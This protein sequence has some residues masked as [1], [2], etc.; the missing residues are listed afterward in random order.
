MS[1]YLRKY[2]NSDSRFLVIDNILVH[3]R[4]QGEGTPVL[5]LHGAFSSLHTYDVWTDYLLDNG[6]RVIRYDLPGF[7][8]TGS[9]L[10]K[11]YS[12]DMYKRSLLAVM[13]GLNLDNCHIV[14]NSLGGWLAWEFALSY[15]ER[16]NRIVLIASAGFLDEKSI[17]LPFKMAKTPFINKIIKY[18][19]KKTVF[20]QFVRQ[21]YGD[22]D[23]VDT[24]LIERY[25]DLFSREGNPDAFLNLCNQKPKDN[26]HKLKKITNE[27]LIIWGDRDAWIPVE[28]AYRFNIQMPNSK[29]I[30][31]EGIG[32]VPMEEIP[33][34]TVTDTMGFLDSNVS[35]SPKM[36]VGYSA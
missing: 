34:L 21:V 15:P 29:L 25:Y 26:T 6:F 10:D 12:M 35:H 28:N 19:V 33:E 2:T 11:D 27:T 7:G 32:H 8:L 20:E 3:Y 14:G 4:D 17:P 13:D 1:Y 23:R 22:P 24:S 18:V 5:L 31:Y 36:V 30:I 16:I 9:R